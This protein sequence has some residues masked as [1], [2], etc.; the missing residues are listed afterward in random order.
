MTIFRMLLVA[1]FSIISSN[2][3]YAEYFGNLNDPISSIY[4]EED[5]IREAHNVFDL[6]DSTSVTRYSLT[7]VINIP[8]V[9]ATLQSIY[10]IQ[11]TNYEGLV[12]LNINGVTFDRPTL[13]IDGGDLYSILGFNLKNMVT[14]GNLQ[15]TFKSE[16][17]GG[18]R[19]AT[20]DLSILFNPTFEITQHIDNVDPINNW[21]TVE[22]TGK[23]LLFGLYYTSVSAVPEPNSSSLFTLGFL[24]I[25]MLYKRKSI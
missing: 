13:S 9:S 2:S 12:S 11:E 1:S 15:L 5:K 14:S 20:T 22:N 3:A 10:F 7:Q 8:T 16:P 18:S 6:V 23:T 25:G 19:V 17:F 4:I 21:T 24:M